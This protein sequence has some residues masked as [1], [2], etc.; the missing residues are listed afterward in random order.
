MKNQ[1]S[2]QQ[3]RINKK[4]DKSIHLACLRTKKGK[5]LAIASNDEFFHAE[6]NVIKKVKRLYTKKEIKN[7]CLR[8]GGFII[9]V[10][11]INKKG[12][13][14]LLSKPCKNCQKAIKKCKGIIAVRHS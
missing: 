5:I 14:F 10:V 13:D 7:L 4:C 11:R 3:F 12:E 2:L 1:K 8:G 9:E 6:V